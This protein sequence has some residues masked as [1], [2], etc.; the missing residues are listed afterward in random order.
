MGEAKRRRSA[1][2][3]AGEA[4]P[5]SFGKDRHERERS[6]YKSE[7][8]R[9]TR[10]AYKKQGHAAFEVTERATALHEAGHAVVARSIAGEIHETINL[11]QKTVDDPL[12]GPTL[13]LG[14]CIYAEGSLF[15]RTMDV[16]VDPVE[17][18]FAVCVHMIA[19]Q[20]AE[21]MCDRDD[22]REGSS[23]NETVQAGACLLGLGDSRLGL[24]DNGAALIPLAKT[25]AWRV[26]DLNRE[27]VERLAARIDAARLGYGVGLRPARVRAETKR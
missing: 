2:L 25:V 15:A 20:A 19:G 27:A 22:Y 9:A 16:R 21:F 12:A 17:D 13:R 24:G 7:L 5:K 26:L 4:R 10:H 3:I 18:V 1:G 23:L 14:E 6:I 8:T 11:E